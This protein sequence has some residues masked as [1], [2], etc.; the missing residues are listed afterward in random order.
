M[1]DYLSQF[2]GADAVISLFLGLLI[3]GMVIGLVA[4]RGRR[5]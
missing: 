2:G 4:G 3:V 1:A 5:R